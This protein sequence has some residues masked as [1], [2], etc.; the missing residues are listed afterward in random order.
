MIQ[1]K[2][3]NHLTNWELVSV[4]PNSKI[5]NWKDLF[6][7]WA[8]S[9]QSI[10]GFSLVA[11][12][13]LLY[14]LNI[15]IVLIALLSAGIL[16]IIF[17]NVIGSISQ[18]HGLPFPAVLRWSMGVKGA[19]YVALFRGI[20]ALLM[21]GIQT[22]FLSKAIGFLF[23]V[24][25]FSYDASLLDNDLLFLFFM[26]MNLIDWVSLFLTVILQITLFSIGHLYNKKIINFS[27]FFVYFGLFLFSLI[28]FSETT[29]ISINLF[30]SLFE[31]KNFI[32]KENIFP[33]L[34]VTGTMFAYFSILILNFGDFARYVKSDQQL[35][36]GNLSLLLNI[37][38]F[39]IFTI[40]IV[41]MSDSHFGGLE[42]ILTNPM[43][44]IGK[45]DNLY[46][47]FI[48]LIF[49]II[50]SL[51]TNLIANYIP[52]QNVL[53][54]FAPKRL[55]LKSV[56][57]VIGFIGLLIGSTWLV[58]LSQ[59]GILSLIDTLGSFFGSIF[60]IILIDYFY[61]KEKKINNKD[62][63]SLQETG[64]Y[65]FTNGWHIKAIYALLLGFIFSAATIWNLEFKFLQSY[66]WFI[67]AIASSFV[68]YLLSNKN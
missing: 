2:S 14:N 6:C 49:I 37:I 63:Y 54:N 59:N 67:G 5:W 66:S 17:S 52:A 58:L 40:L 25:C 46:L 36:I 65:Y 11:S 42:N 47:S 24:I 22:Y 29:D 16:V 56:S 31:Y 4:N 19:K 50:A 68:Y 32:L 33:Y 26:G 38:L 21:F 57:F 64:Q 43:D 61:V 53:I 8:N 18:K 48:S 10:I 34:S 12:L 45:F 3:N 62:L 9:I 28:L 7:F 39:S 60:G 55:N 13:Y 30:I 15:F 1:E 44:I 41:I 27:A 51:S 23:R 20:V 35:K